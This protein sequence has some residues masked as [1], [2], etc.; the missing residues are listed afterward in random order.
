MQ[1]KT[2]QAD[3]INNR[4]EEKQN[5]DV[6]SILARRIVMELTDSEDDDDDDDSEGWNSDE[7]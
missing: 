4:K 3:K 5:M 1:L 2:L 7:D 6:A